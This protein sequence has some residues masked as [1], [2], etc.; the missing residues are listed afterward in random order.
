MERGEKDLAPPRDFLRQWGERCFRV[1]RLTIFLM[2]N[3][4]LLCRDICAHGWIFCGNI[5]WEH[6]ICDYQTHSDDFCSM[7]I[8]NFSKEMMSNRPLSSQDHSSNPHLNSQIHSMACAKS[9]LAK[10]SPTGLL[11]EDGEGFS[12]PHHPQ[13]GENSPH[14]HTQQCS[15][16]TF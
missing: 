13:K 16:L 9:K 2:K 8:Q 3:E 7:G 14:L 12:I 10:V 1:L 6:K 15:G 11:H 5:F 4:F